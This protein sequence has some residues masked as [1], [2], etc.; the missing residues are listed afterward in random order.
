MRSGE[1]C[2]SAETMIITVGAMLLL[3]PAGTGPPSLR[4]GFL[5]PP[6]VAL[7]LWATLRGQLTPRT[8]SGLT[9]PDRPFDDEIASAG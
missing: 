4:W 6:I 1:A 5:A 9:L 2:G 3:A 8:I 7:V